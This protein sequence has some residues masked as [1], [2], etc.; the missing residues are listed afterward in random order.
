[1]PG[2]FFKN[3]VLDADTVDRL[4]GQLGSL[5][6]YPDTNG[7]K[8]AAARLIDAAG[9]KGQHIGPAGVW[10]R[11]PLVLINRGGA[12]AAEILRLARAIQEDVATRFGVVLELEPAVIG[13]DE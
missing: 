4:R 9:W 10:L 11:Q 1:M 6:T 8:V 13:F 2:S 5:P 12:R 7:I 3:P